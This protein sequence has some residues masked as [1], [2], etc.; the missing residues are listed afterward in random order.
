MRWLAVLRRLT[1]VEL[2]DWPRSLD[3]LNRMDRPTKSTR[4]AIASNITRALG[5]LRWLE[6]SLTSIAIAARKTG[7]GTML[8]ADSM[9]FQTRTTRH[10][11]RSRKS[12][13]TDCVNSTQ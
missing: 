3:W 11:R 4:R 8:R 13:L 1:R 2:P 12:R 5:R 9:A 7:A 6:I 10:P